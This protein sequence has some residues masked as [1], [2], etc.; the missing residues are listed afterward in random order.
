MGTSSTCSNCYNI[1][2]TARGYVYSSQSARTHTRWNVV[3]STNA[4]SMRT[5]R[6]EHILPEKHC[7]RD[8]G[9]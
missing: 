4:L 2:M 3:H 7:P 9:K 8:V 6:M 5:L 1:N